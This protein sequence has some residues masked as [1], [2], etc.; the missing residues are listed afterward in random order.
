MTFRTRFLVL[1]TVLLPALG[2]FARAQQALDLKVGVIDVNRALN[3]S[4]A[5]E[6]SKKVLLAA[7][8]Q[9]ESELK[10]KESDLK[11]MAEE[12]RT[13][14]MLTDAAR[15]QREQ[16]LRN[17][18]VELRQH[19]QEA[20]RELQEQERKLTDSILSELRTVIALVSQEKK[21]DFVLEARAA[22]TILFSRLKFV[23]ITNEVIARYNKIQ[24]GKP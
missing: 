15:G 17:R 14:I 13:N 2:G 8:A 4:D 19:V 24:A 20:Q 11:K 10:A 9:K 6:R 12:L 16:E 5:G 18:E 7:K 1:L 21:L 23:D 3:L 22:E